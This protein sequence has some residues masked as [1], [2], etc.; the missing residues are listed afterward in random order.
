MV[1]R[2]LRYNSQYSLKMTKFISII[3]NLI[4]KSMYYVEFNLLLIFSTLCIIGCILIILVF[5]DIALLVLLDIETVFLDDYLIICSIL[6]GIFVLNILTTRKHI[7][8]NKKLPQWYK[9]AFW[10]LLITNIVWFILIII[11]AIPYIGVH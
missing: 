1:R 5:Y 3:K 2:C 11:P 10:L 9:I 8:Y 4:E 7:S 6:T